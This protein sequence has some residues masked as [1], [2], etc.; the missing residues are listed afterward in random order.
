MGTVKAAAQTN[1]LAS[2]NSRGGCLS[3]QSPQVPRNKLQET[4]SLSDS[5]MY[6]KC[7]G[8]PEWTPMEQKSCGR[9]PPSD[10]QHH[11]VRHPSAGMTQPAPDQAKHVR[12]AQNTRQGRMKSGHREKMGHEPSSPRSPGSYHPWGDLSPWDK[13]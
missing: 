6:G 7:L 8:K 3:P 10:E 4:E 1:S 13:N 11:C 2:R 9:I 5:N 12:R